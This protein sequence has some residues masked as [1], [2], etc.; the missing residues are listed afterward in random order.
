MSCS[1]ASD[2]A[3]G[4]P[5]TLQTLICT[6][7]TDLAHQSP[8]PFRYRLRDAPEQ[9]T[10]AGRFAFFAQLNVDRCTKR[11]A[12]Q[13]IATVRPAF[14][15]AAFHFNRIAAAE[16]LAE[17]TQVAADIDCDCSLL[18]NCSPLT[19][20]HTLL[21]PQ[22]AAQ[23]PQILTTD[24]VVCSVRL[25]RQHFPERRWRIGYNSPGAAASVNHL[26]LHLLHVDER[27]WV[28]DV[29]LA[30]YAPATADRVWRIASDRPTEAF[31]FRIDGDTRV[32]PVS[33]DV[34]RLIERLCDRNVPHNVLIANADAGEQRVFVFA[35]AAHG[36]AQTKDVAAFN[37]A[38]CELS[39]FVPLGDAELYARLTEADVV[40]RMAEQ[41][42]DVWGRLAPEVREMFGVDVQ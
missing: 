5:T 27:L 3:T 16:L 11:R 7:W 19:H 38:V 31:V 32:S 6:R 18:I 42:G 41:A 29:R 10:L 35:R 33:A 40:E 13:T 2:S 37:V 39:G 24:A 22:R 30:P 9:R 1:I 14:D 17:C 34:G 23:R 20:W 12:P 36:S 4:S 28:D 26:H 21:C 15:A 25:L 8:S